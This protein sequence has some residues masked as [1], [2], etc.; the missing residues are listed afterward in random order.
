[1]AEAATTREHSPPAFDFGIVIPETKNAFEVERPVAPRPRGRLCSEEDARIALSNCVCYASLTDQRYLFLNPSS[2]ALKLVSSRS[3][4]PPRSPESSRGHES[5]KA[6]KLWSIPGTNFPACE[7]LRN[8]VKAY[9]ASLPKGREP[10]DPLRLTY[11][12]LTGWV[13]DD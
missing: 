9:I 8:S 11:P 1:M 2:G 12:P 5:P 4:E 3:L 13:I 10:E 6:L 7:I